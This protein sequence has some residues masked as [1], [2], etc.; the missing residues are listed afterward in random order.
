MA[1]NSLRPA[2]S[3][4]RPRRDPLVEAAG[5]GGGSVRRVSFAVLRIFRALGWEKQ[6]AGQQIRR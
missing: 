2:R 1:Q 4:R 5:D 6:T 3:K